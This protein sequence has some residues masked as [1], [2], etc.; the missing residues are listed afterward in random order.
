MKKVSALLLALVLALTLALP[1]ALAG[2]PDLSGQL[3]I[4]YTNDVHGGV[5]L[6][7]DK[8]A[9]GYQMVAQYK[10]DAVATGANVLL[11]DGG[12][13]S[14]G[15]PIVNMSQ[16]A[17]AVEFMN[18]AGYDACAIGNHEFDWGLDNLLQNREKAGFT[19]LA[20]NILRA[21]GGDLIFDAN[22]IYEFDGMKIGVFGLSTPETFT[23]ANPALLGGATFLQGEELYACAQAQIDELLAAG[24]NLIVCVGHMG[25]DEESTGNRSLDV[26]ANTIGIDLFLDAHSHSEVV[27]EVEQKLAEGAE[28]PDTT[29]LVSSG[30]AT[31]NV[32]EVVFDGE[33]LRACLIPASPSLVASQAGDADVAALVNS[34][35]TAVD[36]QLSAVFATTTVTL[37]GERKPGVRTEETNLGDFCADAL[38]WA[39]SKYAAEPAVCALTN[40]GGIRA[41]IE[42]GDIT[43]KTMKTVFPFGNKV[44]TIKVTGAE[45]LE[46]LEAA[47]FASP[48]ALGAFPQVAGIEFTLDTTVPYE[49]GEQYADSTYYAPAKPGARVTIATVGGEAFDPEKLY[50][51]ATNDFTA[52]GGDTYIVFKYPA[53]QTLVDTGVALEDALV[54]YTKEVLG[55][56][57]GEQYAAPA[58]RI[59]I[60]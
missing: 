60:K 58:G 28:K 46:A 4:L 52:V 43:M 10:K 15:Q 19:F 53:A 18:A 5:L 1:V 21:A 25:I 3:V 14:Q 17:Q 20:A 31:A 6:D 36:E 33:S 29:L 8:P 56:A 54:E 32:A 23:K 57:I 49:N 27:E 7:P 2:A 34:V 26:I 30:T 12:D 40:G 9:M 22:K 59:T 41:S 37:N 50:V 11:F 47:T 38:L 48:E 24:C 35:N 51:L 44:V 45:L 55:G 42:A 13:F 16:G 39:A